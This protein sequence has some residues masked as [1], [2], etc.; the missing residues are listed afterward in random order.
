MKKN[1]EK[2]KEK[3]A[4]YIAISPFFILFTIFGLYPLIATIYMSFFKWD[5]LGSHIFK[6]F[7]N[8]KYLLEDP[9]FF[10]SIINTFLIWLLTTI[11]QLF[12]CILL[13]VILNQTF[14]KGRNFFRLAVYIP[15]ITSTVAVA[16]IFAVV[17]SKDFGLMNGFLGIFNIPPIYWKGSHGATIFALASMVNWRAIGQG[18]IIFLAALQGISKS[19]YE[20]AELDGA[21]NARKFFNITIPLLKPIIIFKLIISTIGGLN[22]FAEPLVFS[23][24]GGGSNGQGI[25][26]ALYM[27]EEAFIRNNFG[28]ASGIACDMLIIVALAVILNYT[29]S[30]H[31]SGEI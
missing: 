11:P 20:A 21:S 8:Y 2:S 22:V 15:H 31:L 9:V 24:T 23:G 10:K 27:Y 29:V 13:A 7:T 6:G 30:K 5:I 16:L 3:T 17:Y 28:Y 12:I 4:A 25:T 14:V 18:V 1:T 26:M 19:Y